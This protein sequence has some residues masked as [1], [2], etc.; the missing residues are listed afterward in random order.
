MGSSPRILVF[1]RKCRSD[2]SSTM[3][4]RRCKRYCFRFFFWS[5]HPLRAPTIS[6]PSILPTLFIGLD[7]TPLD[8]DVAIDPVMRVVFGSTDGTKI[9]FIFSIL[10]FFSSR[11][12]FL[13]VI[14]FIYLRDSKV[15]L[16][17]NVL[18]ELQTDRHHRESW[19]RRGVEVLALNWILATSQ[20]FTPPPIF[21]CL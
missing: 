9:A 7:G 4:Y 2:A 14:Y 5:T 16:P 21:S 15:N 13:L 18:V 6:I 8:D 20:Y 17:A 1:I 12:Q 3:P 11:F 10:S 19:L